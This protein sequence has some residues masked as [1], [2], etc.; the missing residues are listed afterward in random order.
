MKTTKTIESLIENELGIT[1][2]NCVIE[3]DV[4]IKGNYKSTCFR[5]VLVNDFYKNHY[6][7]IRYWGDGS[8]S[9][10]F[11]HTQEEAKKEML[12]IITTWLC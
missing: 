11:N 9:I 12:H 10:K 3:Q 1:K 2:D 6:Y 5:L 7:I 8:Y 4:T